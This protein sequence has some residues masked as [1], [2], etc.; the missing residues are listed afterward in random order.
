[1]NLYKIIEENN[2]TSQ[3]M[4][5]ILLTSNEG[6]NG[7]IKSGNDNNPSQRKSINSPNKSGMV[8]TILKMLEEN[9]FNSSNKLINNIDPSQNYRREYYQQ[10]EKVKE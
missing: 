6:N 2:F 8:M 1:M 9:N 7:P 10:S 3:R 5:I 4:I